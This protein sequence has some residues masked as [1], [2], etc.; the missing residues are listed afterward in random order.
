M[1]RGAIAR[2]I[3]TRALDA[4]EG[5]KSF[6]GSNNEWSFDASASKDDV[7]VFKRGGNNKSASGKQ[8]AVG[9]EIKAEVAEFPSSNNTL[10]AQRVAKKRPAS[11]AATAAAASKR[12]AR[13]ALPLAVSNQNKSSSG[14]ALK[15][16]AA[17][18]GLR[19]QSHAPSP[20]QKRS[21]K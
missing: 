5:L 1:A 13:K 11:A 18:R 7:F 19:S 2:F 4:P 8:S 12:P 21:R 17:K 15:P 6:T 16:T 20:S 9:K 10:T 14:T 3:A